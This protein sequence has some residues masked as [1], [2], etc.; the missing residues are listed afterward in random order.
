M[1]TDL[2]A[3]RLAID[4]L[5]APSRLRAA[6]S[7]PLPGGVI[8]LLRLAARDETAEI[9]A[10]QASGRSREIVRDAALFFIEQVL[11]DVRSDSYRILGG[12]RQ[13]PTGEL[14][15]NMALL[16]RGVHPDLERDRDRSAA[17]AKVIRAWNDV[18]TPQRRVSYD[19][20]LS[21]RDAS[22]GSNGR[23]GSSRHGLAALERRSHVRQ[24]ASAAPAAEPSSKCLRAILFLVGRRITRGWLRS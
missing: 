8:L 10:A 24:H 2:T 19:Q 5:H 22:K 17:A 13:T 9:A 21:S 23:A 1:T 4:L 7:R 20:A 12:D 18:R 3:L 6:R 14:R 16:L 11:F 15:R